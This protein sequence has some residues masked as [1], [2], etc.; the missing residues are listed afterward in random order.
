MAEETLVREQMAFRAIKELGAHVEYARHFT[1]DARLMTVIRGGLV[2]RPSFV[3]YF[4]MGLNVSL[5]TDDPLQ[6]H[7]TKEPLMEEYSVAAQVWTQPMATMKVFTTPMF[8]TRPVLFP[9]I[10][11]GAQLALLVGETSPSFSR[12]LF[13]PARSS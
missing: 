1:C 4:S 6:L 11:Q 12:I 8:E 5:S 13:P 9:R 10:A 3:R 7:F 2:A